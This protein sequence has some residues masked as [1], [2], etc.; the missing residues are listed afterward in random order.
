MPERIAALLIRSVRTSRGSAR[1]CR[2][3]W[4]TGDHRVTQ[5][6]LRE[7]LVEVRGEGVVVVADRRLAG[8]AEAAT[9]VRDDAEPRLEQRRD[10]LLPRAGAEREAVDQ[11]DRLSRADVLVMDGD[12][13]GVLLADGDV[14]HVVTVARR[15]TGRAGHSHWS[16]A[17]APSGSS[18]SSLTYEP[19]ANSVMRYVVEIDDCLS[20]HASG[21]LLGPPRL[22][23]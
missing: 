22:G 19:T 3:P 20:N 10:L 4:R 5:V 17:L 18:S 23:N 2:R 15:A 8:V 11:D 21:A 13:R 7:Q 9:V 12:G 14:G 6:E 1:P 16:D